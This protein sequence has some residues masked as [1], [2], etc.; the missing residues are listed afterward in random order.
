VAKTTAAQERFCEALSAC[1]NIRTA[2]KRAGVGRS[3]F[4]RWFD[5]D[6]PFRRKVCLAFRMWCEGIQDEAL[7]LPS[8]SVDDYITRGLGI[9]RTES[10]GFA[11]LE[12]G[13]VVRRRRDRIGP[14]EIIP[15]RWLSKDQPLSVAEAQQIIEQWR[16]RASV[17]LAL[18]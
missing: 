15:P 13:R 11:L 12:I 5:E 8:R 9:L 10:F 14:K 7:M 17:L 6:E 18:F 16:K 2:G 3:T 1:G 4:Y